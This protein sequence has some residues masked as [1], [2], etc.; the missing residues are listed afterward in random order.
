MLF[1]I[2]SL[3]F[4]HDRTRARRASAA[5]IWRCWGASAG[6][7]GFISGPRRAGGLLDAVRVRQADG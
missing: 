5:R 7:I 6:T 2:V 3:F 1:G 4:G